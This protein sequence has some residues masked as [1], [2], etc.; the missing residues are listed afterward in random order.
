MDMHRHRPRNKREVWIGERWGDIRIVPAVIQRAVR[1]WITLRK[2]SGDRTLIHHRDSNFVELLWN[3]R[4]P[5]VAYF[6]TGRGT[7]RTIDIGAPPK[8]SSLGRNRIDDHL[9]PC[10]HAGRIQ[11]PNK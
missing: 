3:F 9:S 5:L 7:M 6:V 1:H 4:H 10:C 2:N 11:P 8:P